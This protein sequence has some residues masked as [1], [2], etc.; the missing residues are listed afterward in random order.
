MIS[1]YESASDATTWDEGAGREVMGFVVLSL[2]RF[3]HT[4]QQRPIDIV[5]VFNRKGAVGEMEEAHRQHALRIVGRKTRS[6]VERGAEEHGPEL[7]HIWLRLRRRQNTAST[8]LQ[9]LSRIC[10]RSYLPMP[11]R[12]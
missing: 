6:L 7:A 9:N 3:M 5:N 2:L 10:T 11:L 12:E 4:G 8:D 1:V